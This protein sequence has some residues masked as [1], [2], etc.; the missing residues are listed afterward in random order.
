MH[1]EQLDY[2]RL[3][4]SVVAGQLHQMFIGQPMYT[5]EKYDRMVKEANNK[6][7]WVYACVKKIAQAAASVPLLVYQ[8]DSSGELTEVPN[9]PLQLLLD[10]PNESTS[11]NDFMEAWT[12]FLMLAGNAY[13]EMNGPSQKGPPQELWL[14]RP[15]RTVVVP[16]K[17]GAERLRY[18]VNGTE[19]DLPYER[20]LHTKFFHPTDDYY[21]LTPLQVV[22]RTVDMD[23]STTDWNTTLVQNYGAPGGILKA[24][25]DTQ[26]PK[27]Q[28][29]RIRR[30]IKRMFGGKNNAGKTHLL[31]GGLEWQQLGLSPKDMDFIDSRR[32]TREEICAVFGVPPQIVGIQDK[33]TYNNY[34]EARQSFYQDTVLPA[35][36]DKIVSTINHGLAPL[37]GDNV[38]VGYDKSQIEALQ[39]SADARYKRVK[40]VLPILLVNEARQELGWEPIEGGD[41]RL[42]PRSM[43]EVPLSGNAAPDDPP[44][45]EPDEPN[46]EDK[47]MQTVLQAKRM[48]QLK[49]VADRFNDD[50]DRM[51]A[52]AS[53]LIAKQFEVEWEAI[54]QAIDEYS[55]ADK[56]DEG[57]AQIIMLSIADAIDAQ[58]ED[59]LALMIALNTHA[60]AKHFA[61]S[62]EGIKQSVMHLQRKFDPY[63]FED[64][65]EYMRN[66]IV[67]SASEQIQYISDWTKEEI[68]QIFLEALTEDMSIGSVAM[69]LKTL[70]FE[71][72]STYRAYRI[73]R[74]EMMAAASYGKQQGV[75][76]LDLPINKTWIATADSR[77]RTSH[78]SAHGQT[79]DV[80]EYYNINGFDA[81]HP[82]D[83][84][85]PASERVH[86]RCTEVYEVRMEEI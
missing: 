46:G 33:S 11:R 56:L 77:T 47:A 71:E 22:R 57:A 13:V 85:L 70:Y 52:G 5:E 69:Q 35:A 68:R 81:M 29:Q 65:T 76:S 8:K 10:K 21:G 12:A 67:N 31:E 26:I 64:I 19:I 7:I 24:P 6:N 55:K 74:T 2:L 20:A 51:A 40:E 4:A 42:V 83:S 62:R 53:K 66:F 37:Y 75:L 41:V 73:A 63:E 39:E 49:D 44:Q 14:W 38:I 23:N 9:H 50:V 3:K 28:L 36:L 84:D 17:E 86:C 78:A 48:L 25:P 54:S 60:A 34:A 16:G 30:T 1:K 27:P 32:M 61:E 45:T 43:V 82:G 18:L 15:D 59:W 80:K 79:V 58:Q 72:F